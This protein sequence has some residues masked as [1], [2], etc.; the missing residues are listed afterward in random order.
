MTSNAPAV[1]T[2]KWFEGGF[3]RAATSM[4]S[5]DRVVGRPARVQQVCCNVVARRSVMKGMTASRF[6]LWL[7]S[8]LLSGVIGLVGC[9]H[10]AASKPEVTRAGEGAAPAASLA[11][12][13][14]TPD[15]R[16]VVRTGAMSLRCTDLNATAEQLRQLAQSMDGYVASESIGA[17][18][19]SASG[20]S[21]IV[22][23]VPAANLDRF[24]AEAA[25]LGDLV[26]RSVTARDVTEQVVDVEARIRT[27][28]ESISR[29]RALMDKAGSITEI[30]RVEE[31]LTRRQ[32]ELE[33]LLAK[34]KA[35]KNQVERA[36]VTV[37]LLRPGQVETQNPFLVGL[38][39]GWDALQNSIA[40]LL[41]LVGG[42]LPFV[43]IGGAIGW[44]TVRRFRRRSATP[45]PTATTPPDASG[46]HAGGQAEQ[47]DHDG[48]DQP[49]Q[50]RLQPG[51]S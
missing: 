37:S 24:M 23:S 34:Q 27:L 48:G 5:R 40:V 9:T 19:D 51:T 1:S 14:G 3:Y 20:G 12:E 21:R 35:L 22:F 13:E 49:E 43:L 25:K 6:R 33:A 18:T 38:S 39:Q 42:L 17:D 32:S 2:K 31:E 15:Q 44:P 7:P 29:I 28:R 46:Q 26:T 41:T 11:P 8:L 47:G 36:P 45:K 30:A 4:S 50:D 16:Q 10:D